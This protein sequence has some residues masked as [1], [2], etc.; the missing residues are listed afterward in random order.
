MGDTHHQNPLFL[1]P[2]QPRL[3]P[4]GKGLTN[5]APQN[6]TPNGHW[7]LSRRWSFPHPKTESVLELKTELILELKTEPILELKTVARCGRGTDQCRTQKL[8]GSDVELISA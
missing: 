4:G 2:Q 3:L 7:K 1:Q 8:S 5:N 6:N